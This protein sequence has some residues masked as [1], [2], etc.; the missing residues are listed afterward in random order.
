MVLV[1]GLVACL[2]NKCGA[3]YLGYGTFV[4]LGEA[5]LSF[6]HVFPF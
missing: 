5:Y 3:N 6:F 1:G 4:V 2:K